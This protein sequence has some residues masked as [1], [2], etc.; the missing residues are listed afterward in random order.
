MLGATIGA[1]EEGVLARQGKRPDGALDDV[2]VDL[3][4]TIVEEQA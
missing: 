1:G 2:V 4:A 3:D